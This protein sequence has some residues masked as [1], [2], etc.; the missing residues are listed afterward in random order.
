MPIRTVGL[1]A[2]VG[3]AVCTGIAA[4]GAACAAASDSAVPTAP[5]GS[6]APEGDAATPAASDATAAQI[7]GW[8][9]RNDDGS[10]EESGSAPPSA[11]R[12]IHGEVGLNYGSRGYNSEYGVADIPVG[13][14][15]DLIVAASNSQAHF[16][17]GY[18][19]REQSLAVGLYL[20]GAS[21]ASS[22]CSGSN[23]RN[24]YGSGDGF[25]HAGC[26][27]AR[28]GRRDS[29]AQADAAGGE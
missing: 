28:D 16:R 19:G 17:G 15:G 10:V 26:A 25:R 11:K 9:H 14:T 18:G 23:L 12:T 22:S 13:Q 6:G 8:I 1:A 29:V 24:G 20:G 7:S 4:A 3:L 21:P 27:G 2:C 5:A